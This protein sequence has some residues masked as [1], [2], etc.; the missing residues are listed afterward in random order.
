M[1]VSTIIAT[2]QLKADAPSTSFYSPAE[3]LADAQA[4]W[5]DLYAIL[6]E[7]DDDY[8]LVEDYIDSSSFSAVASRRYTYTYDLPEDFYRLRLL[9]YQ[10]SGGMAAFYPAEKMSV[11]NFG[12]TQNSPAYRLNGTTL[13][14]Y[15][16]VGYSTWYL[17]YYPAPEA[18]TTATD[19]A[20]PSNMVP[21]A[22]V[23]QVAAEI[24]RKQGKDPALMLARRNEILETMRRQFSRDD[25]KAQPVKNVFSQGFGTYI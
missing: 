13:V 6:C 3:A 8:F 25:N 1:L 9:Q 15:D 19:L 22:M 14:I 12:N 24:L 2:G 5:N 11:E 16:P 18:L 7:G 4:A 23:Y 17:G 21:D 10:G 20:Y